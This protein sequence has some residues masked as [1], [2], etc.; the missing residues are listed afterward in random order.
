MGVKS[1]AL[2]EPQHKMILISCFE[3]VGCPLHYSD[4]F[5]V[6]LDKTII[7]EPGFTDGKP[8]VIFQVKEE[9]I[10]QTGSLLYCIPWTEFCILTGIEHKG[11]R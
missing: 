3:A 10:R 2:V 9:A 11:H 5:S 1:K 8:F 4:L 6:Q 7:Q